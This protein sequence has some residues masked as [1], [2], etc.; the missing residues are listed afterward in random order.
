MM[1]YYSFLFKVWIFKFKGVGGQKYWIYP[2]LQLL[3]LVDIFGLISKINMDTKVN[4]FIKV[5]GIA[6]RIS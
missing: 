2:S 6:R 1:K 4:S 3:P 5:P